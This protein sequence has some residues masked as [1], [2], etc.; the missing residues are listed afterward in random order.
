MNHS[1]THPLR[2]APQRCDRRP[3][4]SCRNALLT[5]MPS[6]YRAGCQNLAGDGRHRFLVCHRTWPDIQRSTRSG[7]STFAW[8][9]VVRK[10]CTHFTG[11]I[12]PTSGCSKEV[13]ADGPHGR[14]AGLKPIQFN[15]HGPGCR[16]IEIMHAQKGKQAL[17][18]TG[19][20]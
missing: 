9:Q 7:N 19:I 18:C 17:H 8:K 1:Q 16:F 13:V 12:F 6:V 15:Q 11:I 4:S 3:L 2:N 10:A 5:N 14:R 20:Y